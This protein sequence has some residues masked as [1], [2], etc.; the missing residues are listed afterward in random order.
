KDLSS[1]R[2][3]WAEPLC[4]PYRGYSVCVPPPP[5]S[6]VCLLEM[7]SML[8]RTD[9]AGRRPTDP[10]AWFLFAQARRLIYA[11]RARHGADP[12]FVPVPVQRLLDPAYARLRVQLIGQHAGAAPPPGELSMPRGRDATAESAGTS[13]FVI[14]DAD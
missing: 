11:D 8:D 10:Q 7:L 9:I 3:T 1:Y 6:G 5:S 13:H 4:R 14:V 2:A 12:R